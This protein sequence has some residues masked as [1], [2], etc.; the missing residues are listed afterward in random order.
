ME[1]KLLKGTKTREN[2]MKAFAGESMARNRYCIFASMA[3]KEGHIQIAEIFRKTALNEKEH[4][5]T[6]FKFLDG[7]DVEITN[8][9]IPSCL[10]TTMENLLCAA[11]YEEEEHSTMYPEYGKTAEEEGFKNIAATFYN[12]AEIEKHHSIRYKKLADRLEK[13]EMFKS[14]KSI[15]WVCTHCGYIAENTEPPK[16]CPVCGKPHGYFER[17]CDCL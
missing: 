9:S 8:I 16:K 12:I 15:K 13:E 6:Y 1:K 11:K 5:E 7:D 17:F 14:D 4:A 10:G 2:L 3:E